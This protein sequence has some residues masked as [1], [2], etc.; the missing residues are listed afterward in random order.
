MLK[1]KRTLNIFLL[2][3]SLIGYLEWGQGNSSTIAQA[4]WEILVKIWSD[5]A[6]VLHPLTILP[7][8]GQVLLV[9]TLFQKQVHKTLTLIGGACISILFVLILLVGIFSANAKVILS[10]IP[11][12]T[13]FFLTWRVHKK[14]S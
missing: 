11:F 5:P 7:F 10:V 12:L 2:F 14:Q 8:L 6:S 9:I 3:T 1:N 4:E 13:V